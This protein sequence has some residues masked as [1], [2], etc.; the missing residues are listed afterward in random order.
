M[1]L[2]QATICQ[3]NGQ[4]TRNGQILRKVQS[5]KMKPRRNRKDED[6]R[7]NHKH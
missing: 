3:K 4:P 6:E 7:T 1:R 5:Y 2:L